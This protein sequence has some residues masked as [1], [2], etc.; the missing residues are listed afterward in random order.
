MRADPGHPSHCYFEAGRLKFDSDG[1][2]TGSCSEDNWCLCRVQ[3]M[4]CA[5]VLAILGEP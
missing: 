5:V 4:P 2:N 1:R 3:E